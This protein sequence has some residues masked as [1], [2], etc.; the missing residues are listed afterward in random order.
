MFLV[1]IAKKL[2]EQSRRLQVA[3]PLACLGSLRVELI[4]VQAMAEL[5]GILAL[6][7][8]LRRVLLLCD[9]AEILAP[10]QPQES[11]SIIALSAEGLG[12]MADELL[13]PE[14]SFDMAWVV[15]ESD[16]L[17]GRYL[18]LLR[19]L[20]GAHVGRPAQADVGDLDAPP[21][22][23]L[24]RLL[25][26][27]GVTTSPARK[28]PAGSRPLFEIDDEEIPPAISSAQLLKVLLKQPVENK[29]DG[30]SSQRAGG[31]VIITPPSPALQSSPS[32][33]DLPQ[34]PQPAAQVETSPAP[35]SGPKEKFSGPLA[36]PA[37]R[38]AFR[39]DSE[40]LTERI[41]GLLPELERGEQTPSTLRELGRCLHTLKGA[42]GAVG[43]GQ[44][45]EFVHRLEDLNQDA[46]GTTGPVNSELLLGA[47]DLLLQLEHVIVH[48]TDSVPGDPD[49]TV[50][51]ADAVADDAVSS[52]APASP[53]SSVLLGDAV[54]SDVDETVRVPIARLGELMDLV[55][56]L[57]VLNGPRSSLATRVKDF[58]ST[59]R[60]SRNRLAGS[61]DQLCELHAGKSIE[62]AQPPDQAAD[63]ADRDQAFLGVVRHLS[64]QGDDLLILAENLRGVAVPM[65][66]DADIAARLTRHLWDLLH[67]IRVVPIRPLLQRLAAWPAPRPRLKASRSGLCWR[68][69]MPC[70]IV[71][72]RTRSSSRFCTSSG[73]LLDMASSSPPIEPRQART[74]KGR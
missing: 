62:E 21:A 45:A 66:D 19:P 36:D 51:H 58:A 10:D 71:S 7:G 22:I 59:V 30:V 61:I 15:R 32:Q 25:G 41:G 46:I 34:E 8:P 1:S 17:W 38:L 9:I 48:L 47:H 69:K 53:S 49:A 3:N 5:K 12:R 72:C 18:D 73:M 65:A 33:T 26:L 63:S 50:D 31:P 60:S 67:E 13:S 43:L 24:P 57:L 54:V 16:R 35:V 64:E 39:E 4:E 2:Q 14:S 27:L 40:N 6:S 37:T 74:P 28:S 55:A 52:V 29:S 23:D 44:L 20:A 42:A 11:A 56:E 68:E 70:S